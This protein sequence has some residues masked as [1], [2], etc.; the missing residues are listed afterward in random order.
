[1]RKWSWAPTVTLAVLTWTAG[2]YQRWREHRSQQPA[3]WQVT[4][5]QL[6]KVPERFADWELESSQPLEPATEK[7]LRCSAYLNRIYRNRVT[8]DRM[9]VALLVGPAGSLSIHTPEICYASQDYQ[10]VAAPRRVQPRPAGHPDEAF[11]Q[12]TFQNKKPDRG[13][14]QVAYGWKTDGAWRAPSQPR[15]ALGGG[16]SLCKLQIASLLSPGAEAESDSACQDFLHD[17]L[18]VL[19]RALFA[20]PAVERSA[21][22]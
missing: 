11:W 19:E 16:G 9:H 6:A 17:F 15:F 22:D 18:P 10:T 4:S 14:L 5:E 1:M 20:A 8:N 12:T 13:L 3:N 2:G 7:M 21:T